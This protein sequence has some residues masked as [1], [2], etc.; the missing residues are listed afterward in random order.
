MKRVYKIMVFVFLILMMSGCKN[1]T[2][3]SNGNENV[4]S[5]SKTEFKVT[6]DDLYKVLKDKYATNYLIQQVDTEI[7]NKEYKTDDEAKEYV[8]N[9]IKVYKMMY[10]NSDDQLLSAI[11]EAGYRDLTE[12]KEAILLGYKRNLATKNYEKANI[13]EDQIKKYYEKNVYGDITL[14]HILVKLDIKD[15]MTDEEKK[16]AEKKASDKIKEIYEKLTD[17]NFS[18]IAKEYSEDSATKDSG[19]KLGTFSKEEMIEKFNNEFEEAAQNLKVNEY[20]KKVVKSSYGY[21][22]IY[23]TEQKDKPALD[24]VKDTI[25]STLA[26]E[27]LE[28][29]TKAEYKAM[30]KLREDYGLTF[31]DDAIKNQY[32][33]AKNNWL[34][35]KDN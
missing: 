23:K 1:E 2:K 22:I 18:E 25:I 8:E 13:T 19:G 10:G 7:L 9:Q 35:G 27:A 11:Q 28:K 12:F 14:N 16:E 33:V 15:S 32:E 34:Y 6:A 5:L 21:H 4:L 30:I 17:K 26:D 29:D 3:P 20:T 24:K 31:N